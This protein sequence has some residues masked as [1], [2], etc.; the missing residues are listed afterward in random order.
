MNSSEPILSDPGGP[1]NIPVRWNCP[2]VLWSRGA[3]VNLGGMLGEP[4]TLLCFLLGSAILL[5]ARLIAVA[6]VLVDRNY[7]NTKVMCEIMLF[8]S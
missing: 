1:V 5:L 4:R 7:L 8:A 2:A 3:G 6:S